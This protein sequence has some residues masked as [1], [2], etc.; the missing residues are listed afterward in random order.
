MIAWR[1]WSVLAAL[2]VAG[3]AASTARGEGTFRRIKILADKAPDCSSRKAIVESVTRGCKTNDEKAV[4]IYNFCKLAWYHRQ[5]PNEPGGVAALKMINVCGWSLCGGQHSALSSLWAAA[6][7]KHRFVGWPGHTTVE[8][9]YDDRW[10]YFDTFL[11]SYCWMQDPNA[12]GGRTV[13]G[14]GDIAAKPDLV[15]KGLVLDGPRK[16]Y[17][18]AGDQFEV[19]NDKANWVA[20]A[21]LVCGDGPKGVVSGCKAR[22]RSGSPTGWA[23]IIHDEKGYNTDV[24]LAP[25]MSLELMWKALPQSW[26][27]RGQKDSPGHTCTDKDFRNCPVIGPILEP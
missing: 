2:V 8:V 12:P 23:G 22:R 5:Y 7:W 4:A 21:F 3:A 16:V 9:F 11:K 18:H 14:Q 6:G 25:G 13:A 24:N 19:I 26:Y 20:P 15:H 1:Q 27:W 10:H 17:Y